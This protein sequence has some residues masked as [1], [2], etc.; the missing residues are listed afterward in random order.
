M[1]TLEVL[2]I[3]VPVNKI[4]G[5]N[6]QGHYR[7]HMAKLQFLSSLTRAAIAREYIA[8]GGFEVPEIGSLPIMPDG[9]FRLS[10]ELW[11]LRSTAFDLAN[12]SK[13]FKASV[14]V[15]TNLGYWEDDNFNFANQV[16]VSGGSPKFWG[17]AFRY[18]NDGLPDIIDKNWW[19]ENGNKTDAL[20]RI[21]ISD[22]IKVF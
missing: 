2:R 16:T 10:F 9:R 17:N 6:T 19:E 14:D 12:Y 1:A 3:M 11:K 15:F 7:V 21:I 18:E 8:P 22:N 13:T 4:I 20:I 5:D